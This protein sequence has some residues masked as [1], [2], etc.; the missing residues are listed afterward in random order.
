VIFEILAREPWPRCFYD[1]ERM[2]GDRHVDN[3]Q[4]GDPD[5]ENPAWHVAG[6]CECPS[7]PLRVAISTARAWAVREAKRDS[8][9]S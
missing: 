1:Q 6:F 4:P 5:P 3:K 7:C 9:A 2:C 8:G